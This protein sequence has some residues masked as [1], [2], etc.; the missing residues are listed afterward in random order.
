MARGHLE[1]VS[2]LESELAA[3]ESSLATANQAREQAATEVEE[4][5][6]SRQELGSTRDER[7]RLRAAKVDVESE[8]EQ[9]RAQV[10][11]LQSEL[12][13]TELV[14]EHHRARA[15][16]LADAMASAKAAAE[17][18]EQALG[19]HQAKRKELQEERDRLATQSDQFAADAAELRR[20]VQDLEARFEREQEL[21]RE[22]IDDAERRATE[23]GARVNELEA[24]ISETREHAAST[25]RDYEELATHTAELEARLDHEAGQAAEQLEDASAGRAELDDDLAATLERQAEIEP[26]G[27]RLTRVATGIVAGMVLGVLLW[28]G[29]LLVR[30]NPGSSSDAAPDGR[31][32]PAPAFSAVAPASAQPTV[33]PGMSLVAHVRSRRVPIY[34]SPSARRP[35]MTL[36]NPNSIGAPLVFLVETTGAS[37]LRVLLPT[38]PNLSTGWI[39]PGDV[40]LELDPYRLKVELGSHQLLLWR[41]QR[42]VEREPVGVGR[43]AV[44]PTPA[45]LYYVTELLKQSNPSGPYG[46]YAFGLSA[47]SDVLHEFAGG[48]GQVGIHG[49]N[50]PWAVGTDVS[51]GCIRVRN[52]VIRRLAALLPLGT[53]VQ[54]AR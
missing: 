45:G 38:R 44:T 14:R 43:R 49:T 22:R 2:A 36:S 51:H 34:H 28:G 33:P 12:A 4:T 16:E 46:P 19:N 50:E 13:E 3:V 25:E 30:G 48:N 54:I 52:E 5:A 17:Q 29:F 6:F 40:R 21:G 37:R 18:A 20:Q 27:R 10:S 11:G 23:S 41:G 47:H 32:S 31:I 42:L 53:P 39:S 1:R 35:F 9:L 7:Q 15:D 26:S 24:A 8:L